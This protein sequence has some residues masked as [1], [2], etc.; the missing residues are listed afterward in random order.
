[1]D[2]LTPSNLLAYSG[3]IALL[4]VAASV[5]PGLARLNAP[6][7]RYV[8]WQGVLMACLLL[9]LLQT[10]QRV[11][12]EPPPGRAVAG[13]SI[14]LAGAPS[15]AAPPETFDWWTIVLALLCAGTSVRLTW[16]IV[17]AA[18]L[19]RLRRAGVVAPQHEHGEL[20][21]RVGRRAEIRYVD[22]VRQPVT[23]GVYRPVVLL[24]S[25]LRD[26]P[27]DV[28]EAVVAHE[29]SHVRRFDALWVIV[30]EAI[31]A[32]LWFHPAIWWVV[33][34]VRLAREYVVD[35][36]AIGLTGRR[37]AYLQ[38]LLTFAEAPQTAHAT[39][40]G[41]RRHLFDR[42]T[43]IAREDVM[44]STRLLLTSFVLVLAIIVSARYV[45]QAFPMTQETTA[46]AAEF[47]AGP[48][49]RAA[50]PLGPDQPRP[51]KIRDVAPV[52]PDD[53]VAHEMRADI[54]VRVT[55]DQSG[56]VTE[57]RIIGFG[58]AIRGGQLRA[59]GDDTPAKVERMQQVGLR[60][61]P[62]EPMVT[63]SVFRTAF[64]G[65]MDAAV[66][67]A[68]QWQYE[69]VPNGP[70]AFDVT[71]RFEGENVQ[72]TSPPVAADSPLAQGAIRV[73]GNIQPPPKVHDVRPI[74]PDDAKRNGIQG[75]VVMEIRVEGDG[76]VSRAR[77]MESMPALDAAALEAVRQ[78]Q[79]RPT[80]LNGVPTPIVMS[81]TVHFKLE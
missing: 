63:A 27:M 22:A 58:A 33:R 39:A 29:L 42:I 41:G 52:F 67:A 48:L 24:P 18:R 78:W 43:Q 71:I 50:S 75:V 80:L 19:A 79:F 3:Q 21:A 40:F 10:P 7:S 44:S 70:V 11:L 37:R 8:F 65:F 31:R 30:E 13:R 64:R 15:I 49:E 25:A 60:F 26:Q 59:D 53:P 14:A 17:G 76:T 69:P 73:G 16:T 77:V 66:I 38:A 74:Y 72:P 56:A 46:T 34:R 81:T 47:K 36:C 68:R 32:V 20:R 1:M 35:E 57:A 55:L 61:A 54:K 62:S 23:F 9:P 4:V 6:A 2:L 51:V 12:I 45:V 5:L 28:R